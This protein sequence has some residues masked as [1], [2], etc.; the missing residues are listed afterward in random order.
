M[1][2]EVLGGNAVATTIAHFDDNELIIEERMSEQV[3]KDILDHNQKVRSAGLRN[4]NAHGRLAASIP[5]G[6]YNK[7]RKEWRERGRDN[8]EW[9][10]FLAMKLNSREWAFLKTIEGNI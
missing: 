10:T 9:R 5:I 4:R 1:R 2:R 8:W 3:V 7:W 6:L